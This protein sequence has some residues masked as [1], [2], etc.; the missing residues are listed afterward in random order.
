MSNATTGRATGT[1]QLGWAVRRFAWVLML[2]VL[3]LGVLAPALAARRAP[4]Y[5]ARSLVVAQQLELSALTLPRLGEAVFDSG[6]V[7]REVASAPEVAGDPETMIPDRLRV[8]TMQDSVVF[9]VI[10]RDPDP[11]MAALL[12]N[13]G[14]AAFVD[15]LNKPGAGVGTFLLQDQAEPPSRPVPSLST[16]QAGVVGGVAGL[17]LG[18]G[19]IALLLVIR[20]PVVSPQD[21]ASV[22]DLPVLGQVRLPGAGRAEFRGPRG[23]PGLNALTRW[24]LAEEPD[25]LLLTSRPVLTGVRQRLAV[26]LAVAVDRHVPVHLHGTAAMLEAFEVEAVLNSRP[27][28]IRS[29]DS[30]AGAAVHITESSDPMDV[31]SPGK[32]TQ[33]TVLVAPVGIGRKSLQSLVSQYME[34]ELDGIVLVSGHRLFTHSRGGTPDS[35]RHGERSDVVGS[36]GAHNGWVAATGALASSRDTLDRG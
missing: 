1:S 26:M 30:G 7:A 14:A 17:A 28:I 32:R 11:G 12:A 22:T 33:R 8:Q 35:S 3:V 4:V 36:T 34:N 13:L 16:K 23:V 24:V 10:G 27:G 18:A 20:R 31:L 6:A 15:Q 21:A 19:V 25:I 5:E 2:G 29:L 9:T